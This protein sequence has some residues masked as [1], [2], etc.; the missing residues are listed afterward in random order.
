MS[1]N[2]SNTT[3]SVI[4]APRRNNYYYGQ[5]LDVLQLQQEQGYGMQMRRLSNRLTLG[6]GVLCGLS[7]SGTEDQLV[8]VSPG[9]AI[10]PH[11]REL[12]VPVKVCVDPWAIADECGKVTGQ[13]SKD[14]RHTV[15]LELCYRE[16]LTDYAPVLVSDCNAQERCLPGTVIESFT[17]R[18]VDAPVTPAPSVLGQHCCDK[19]L[20]SSDTGTGTGTATYEVMET[21]DVDNRPRYA[22]ASPDG[23]W[24]VVINAG[25]YMPIVQVIDVQ[26]SAVRSEGWDNIKAPLG[27]ISIAPEGGNAFITSAT[28]V[29][30]VAYAPDPMGL[31]D[32]FLSDIRYGPCA[33]AQRGKLLFAVEDEDG[34]VHVIDIPT[35]SV[36]ETLDLGGRVIDLAVTSDGKSLFALLGG[37][38]E[39]QQLRVSDRAVLSTWTGAGAPMKSLAV[40]TTAEGGYQV[41]LAGDEEALVLDPGRGEVSRPMVGVT[42]MDSGL[43]SDGT[44]YFVVSSTGSSATGELHVFDTTTGTKLDQVSLGVSS[45]AVAIVPGRTRAYIPNSKSGTVSVVEETMA[46]SPPG[47]SID[48]PRASCRCTAG[49]CPEPHADCV[50]LAQIEL[51]PGGTIGGCDECLVR[52]RLYSNQMLFE[53]IM[54]LARRLDECCSGGARPSPGGAG[55]LDPAPD[56]QS[57]SGGTEPP[58]SGAPA[59]S[60][61]PAESG[62]PTEPGDR[63]RPGDID[64]PRPR[65]IITPE[66][67]RDR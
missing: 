30:R 12:V 9:A 58:E 15:V 32:S 24:V 4:E 67:R 28:G 42:P 22:V 20:S 5:M 25:D 47:T 44:R 63:P 7:L 43:T 27:G 54:C 29:A 46:P 14:E 50:P 17:L 65:D 53:L 37:R 45:T 51:L 6:H 64:V 56:D 57:G 38:R 34:H 13:R 36:I 3:K 18:T 23:K 8:C 26:T 10:D 39:V 60:G 33:A 48:R 61:V 40:H 41:L 66:T 19:L 11:G 2:E 49:P 16:C 1:R 52:P 55:G 59:G 31:L 62:D 35:K 21:I